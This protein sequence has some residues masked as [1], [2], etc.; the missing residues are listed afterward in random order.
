MPLGNGILQIRGPKTEP[1]D[2]R[3]GIK[4]GPQ[5]PRVQAL[6]RTSGRAAMKIEEEPYLG[7]SS[8]KATN[9]RRPS[10]SGVGWT[11]RSAQYGLVS[12][13]PILWVS[14]SLEPVREGR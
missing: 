11:S 12:C 7:Q 6:S 13:F 8:R 9:R 5:A 2:A 4:D 3:G 14:L 1:R 10:C